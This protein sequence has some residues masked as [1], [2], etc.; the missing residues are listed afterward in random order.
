V[1]VAGPVTRRQVAAVL[2][3]DLAWFGVQEIPGLLDR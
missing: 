3:T 1:S 2:T